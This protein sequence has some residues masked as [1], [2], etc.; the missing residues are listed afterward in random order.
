M[1]AAPPLTLTVCCVLAVR[2]RVLDRPGHELDLGARGRLSLLVTEPPVDGDL[3]QVRRDRGGH[4][5]GAAAA[6]SPP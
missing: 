4:T 1:A 2:Q 5:R 6:A 3:L